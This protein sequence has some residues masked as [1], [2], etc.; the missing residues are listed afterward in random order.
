LGIVAWQYGADHS[1]VE[2]PMAEVL[3]L[4]IGSTAAV[5]LNAALQWWGARRVGVTVVPAAGWRD[6]QV[7]K[8]VRRATR[9]IGQ[10][11]LLALQM[12]GLLLLANRI[13]G[14]TVAVQIA[15]NFY[16]LPIAVVATP[17]ALALL[18]RLARLN[19]PG[20]EADFADTFRQGL[21]LALFMTI[22]A[23]VGYLVLADPIAHLVA[24]GQMASTAGLAMISGSL[25]SLALGLVGQTTFLVTMQ[26]AYARHDTRAPLISMALQAVV[27]LALLGVAA[28]ADGTRLVTLASMA[29]AVGAATGAIHLLSRVRRSLSDGRV[30]L[31]P[32]VLR[33]SGAALLMAAPVTLVSQ[34]ISGEVPGK[35]GWVLTLVVGG[36]V[37]LAIVWGAAALS[38][39]PELQ[40]IAAAVRGRRTKH[41]T[42]AAEP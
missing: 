42:E 41:Q 29:Y 33:T 38:R 20:Q 17:V 39:A 23:A 25:A 2:Q 24:A 36:T 35:T 11:G 5:A 40:W 14:G 8:L 3:L 6:P 15:L 30:K 34:A 10:A 19:A 13:E 21:S 31:W 26:A 28:R 4:G 12:L 18:P 1:S 9:S 27:F 16:Y 37:G 32:S 7:R 22:P